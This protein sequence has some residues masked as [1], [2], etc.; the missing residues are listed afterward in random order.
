MESSIQQYLSK[1]RA[2][3]DKNKGIKNKQ[4]DLKNCL[5]QTGLGEKTYKRSQDLKTEQQATGLNERATGLL[6]KAKNSIGKEQ[7]NT[8]L[9]K[10]TEGKR[11][12]Q[13]DLKRE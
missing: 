4:Q 12:K 11:N 9:N 5:K 10:R 7:Q 8:E 13:Q 3:N 1:K 6:E 2:T